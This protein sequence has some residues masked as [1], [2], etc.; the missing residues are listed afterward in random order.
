MTSLDVGWVCC[1]NVSSWINLSDMADWLCCQNPEFRS[2]LLHR[3]VQWVGG[4]KMDSKKPG[5]VPVSP[6]VCP[7]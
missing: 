3:F 1:L 5:R 2:Q 7:G 6:S 4:P